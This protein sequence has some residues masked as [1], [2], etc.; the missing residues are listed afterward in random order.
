M[1]WIRASVRIGPNLLFEK[2]RTN[3]KIMFVIE[4]SWHAEPLGEE[5]LTWVDAMQEVHRLASIP[6][7]KEPNLAPCTG[8]RDCGR[9]YEI[10]EY[11]TNGESWKFIS[12][13][14]VLEIDAKGI[15]WDNFKD[16]TP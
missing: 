8:W 14:S 5:H 11:K 16:R 9:K 13:H 7:D 3:P 1:V 12:R 6:W 10:I 2:E 15:R 4:D